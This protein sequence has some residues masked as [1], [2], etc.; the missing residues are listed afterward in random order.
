MIKELAWDSALFKKKIGELVPASQGPFCMEEVLQKAGEDRFEYIICR[1]KSHNARFIRL[2]E[3]SG[4]YLTDIGVILGTKAGAFIQKNMRLDSEIRGS[5]RIASHQDIP[6]LK[7]ISSSLFIESRFYNDPFFSKAMA[8][9]LYRAWIENSVKGQ[10]ADIVLYIP[11]TGFITCR[12]SSGKK[13]E[14]VLM[15]VKKNFRGKGF[16]SGLVGE[17]MQWFVEQEIKTVTVRTQ[18]KN[19]KALNFY[20]TLGFLPQEYDIVFGKIL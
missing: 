8:D 7:R 5:I 1:T 13:G 17:A 11:G 4:F 19:L 3:A 2:L 16:G 10:A 18:L 15:G 12:K 6:D 14:I 20:L 9:R